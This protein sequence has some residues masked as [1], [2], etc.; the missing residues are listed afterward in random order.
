[1][2]DDRAGSIKTQVFFAPLNVIGEDEE[3][4]IVDLT[5]NCLGG[6]MI[7]VHYCPVDETRAGGN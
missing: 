7:V 1:M 2:S 3:V 6:A 5:E 4:R